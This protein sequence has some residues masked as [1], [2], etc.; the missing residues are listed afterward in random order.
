MLCDTI[1]LMA[2][3]KNRVIRYIEDDFWKPILILSYFLIEQ[4]DTEVTIDENEELLPNEDYANEPKKNII[5][6]GLCYQILNSKNDRAKNCNQR[7]SNALETIATLLDYYI[8]KDAKPL[9]LQSILSKGRNQQYSAFEA[10]SNYYEISEDELDE[11]LLIKLDTIAK[12]T[13]NQDIASTCLEILINAGVID[14][15]EAI[16]KMDDWKHEHW[17]L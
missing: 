12:E 11:G 17:G 13:D 8:I 2:K 3:T 15:M 10:L 14:E 7:R 16:C 4:S 6:L 9:F 5:I 1:L